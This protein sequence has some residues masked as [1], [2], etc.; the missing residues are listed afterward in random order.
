MNKNGFVVSVVLMISIT[1]MASKAIADAQVETTP[2]HEGPATG[3]VS[4]DKS[5]DA[6]KN[7]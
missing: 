4:D 1:R 7:Q 3:F 5:G 6:Q 2:E